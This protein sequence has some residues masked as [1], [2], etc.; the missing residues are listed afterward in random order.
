[1]SSFLCCFVV[2]CARWPVYEQLCS[3]HRTTCLREIMLKEYRLYK[4]YAFEI[5]N[6][7]NYFVIML[8]WFCVL[9]CCLY[10]NLLSPSSLS[11]SRCPLRLPP[12]SVPLPL[13]LSVSFLLCLDVLFRMIGG[14]LELKTELHYTTVCVSLLKCRLL[15]KKKNRTPKTIT[16][17]CFRLTVLVKDPQA[18]GNQGLKVAFSRVP[19]RIF[20]RTPR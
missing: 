9:L 10:T 4:N 13:T 19:W 12:F 7:V 2:G 8:T 14:L 17:V 16:P 11:L 6:E 1:M 20:C 3:T 15:E 18:V 5:V